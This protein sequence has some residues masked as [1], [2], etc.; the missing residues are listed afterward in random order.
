MPE[1]IPPRLAAAPPPALAGPGAPSVVDR[2][3]GSSGIS[4]GWLVAGVVAGL[5]FATLLFFHRPQG[6][7]FFPRCTFHTV[8]GL[9][10]PGCG[11]LRATHELLHGHWFAALRCN[12]LYVLGVP[13][14]L[15]GWWWRRRTGRGFDLSARH[16][17]I[18]L[19][20]I[21]LFTLLRNVPWPPFVWLAPPAG[22]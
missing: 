18:L 9:W 7:F 12:A 8:T 19:A 6:Q 22:A 16:G 14:A 2:A 13:L 5:A 1:T 4:R 20:V 3:T 17:W 10:C 21:V 11:G 15:G